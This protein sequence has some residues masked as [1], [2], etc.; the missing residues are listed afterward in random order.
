[1]LTLQ[2]HNITGDKSI[3]GDAH[4]DHTF[5]SNRTIYRS[6]EETLNR[7]RIHALAPGCGHRDFFQKWGKGANA[8]GAREFA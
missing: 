1:M 4:M 6:L 5:N 7:T 2:M 3:A 8:K